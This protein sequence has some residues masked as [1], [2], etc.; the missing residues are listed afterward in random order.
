VNKPEYVL[1]VAKLKLEFLRLLTEDSP[2]GDKR[3]KDFNQ[4]IFDKEKG[5]A[6]FNGTDL[7]MIMEKFNKAAYNLTGDR[8][9][10]RGEL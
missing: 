7:E 5:Y 4:A 3:R 8:A 9:F 2:H 6:V 10:I 1:S